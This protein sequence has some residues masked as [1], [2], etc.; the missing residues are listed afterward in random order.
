[1]K[2]LDHPATHHK[3]PKHQFPHLMSHQDHCQSNKQIWHQPRR[4]TAPRKHNQPPNNASGLKNSNRFLSNTLDL[5]MSVHKDLWVYCE[6]D[7]GFLEGD[8]LSDR[9]FPIVSYVN[10]KK[11]LRDDLRLRFI[12]EYLGQLKSWSSKKPSRQ[13]SLEEVVLVENDMDKRVQWPLGRV[14]NLIP[15]KDG[16]DPTCVGKYC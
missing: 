13:I 9:L 15:G 12:W 16:T 11:K 6:N 4:T 14:S 8:G 1:M 3:S 7:I 5:Y 10:D 2:H